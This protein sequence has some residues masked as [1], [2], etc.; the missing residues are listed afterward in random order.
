VE[1]HR[2]ATDLLQLRLWR[3]IINMWHPATPVAL[4]PWLPL[5]APQHGQQKSC[6]LA[7]FTTSTPPAA[8]AYLLVKFIKYF[9]GRCLCFVTLFSCPPLFFICIFFFWPSHFLCT[10]KLLTFLILK[11][12]LAHIFTAANV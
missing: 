7:V 12:L 9:C 5:D 6:A 10:A 3:T 8:G 11:K 1:S 4:N 2:V